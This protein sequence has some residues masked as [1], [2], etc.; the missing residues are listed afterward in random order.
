[1]YMILIALAAGSVA[2]RILSLPTQSHA[3]NDGSRWATVRALV[4]NGTYSIGRREIDADSGT[5]H[6]YGI[7]TQP[8]WKTID[9]VLRPGEGTRY[10]YSSKLPLLPTLVAGEYWLLKNTLGWSIVDNGISVTRTILFTINWLPMVIYLFVMVRLVEMLGVTAWGRLFVMAA[11]AL[12]TYV[13]LF[14]VTFNDHTIAACSAL[15]ALDPAL[16]IWCGG[17]RGAGCFVLAGFFA[18]FTACNQLPA[19]S[20]LC[21]LGLCFLIR[22]PRQTLFFFMPA[23]MIPIAGLLVTNYL[24]IG[25]FFPAYSEFG[26]PWYNFKGSHWAEPG[27][28]IDWAREPKTVYAFHLLFGHHGLFSLTPIFLLSVAGSWLW[29]SSRG[30][31]E[32]RVGRALGRLTCLLVPVVVGFYV[33][34]TNN[35]GGWSNGPRWLIWLIPFL[36]LTMLP[37]ADWLAGRRWGRGLACVLLV[38]S[39]LSVNYRPLN[40]WRHP[41]IY[42]YLEWK[43][44]IRY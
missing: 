12:G 44:W 13:N 20:F 11:A 43:G 1:M 40:P 32:R 16:R 35:Y 17:R 2:G 42:D 7:I 9:C 5:Y 34:R 38:L 18:A 26:G 29:A 21:V 36:V 37:A 24:A 31:P 23:A 6:D 28:G 27:T 25:Q 33:V 4:D 15:F 41:W 22:F 14:L 10:F 19:T 8:G 3:D 39:V 30:R